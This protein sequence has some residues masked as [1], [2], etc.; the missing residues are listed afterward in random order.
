[1]VNSF[2]PDS[3][4]PSEGIP[5][6]ISQQPYMGE[7]Q[8]AF[9]YQR[10]QTMRED[11]IARIRTAQHSMGERPELND[12]ADLAQYEKDSRM[13]LRNVQRESM[14]LRK[15]DASLERIRTGDYG[16]C[17]ETGEPIGIQRLLIRPTA[18]YCIEVKNHMEQKEKHYDKHR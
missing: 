16:Y 9:F 10:L 5:K 4:A 17:S 15:I 6:E 1:M 8:R 12:D 18:E 13:T 3:A 11:T 14:L 7:Q 2:N